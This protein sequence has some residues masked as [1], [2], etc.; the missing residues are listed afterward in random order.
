M[1]KLL[2]AASAIAMAVSVPAA[3][4]PDKANGGKGNGHAA[5]NMKPQKAERQAAKQHKQLKPQKQQAKFAKNERKAVQRQIKEENKRFERVREARWDD[6]R[7]VR[8]DRDDRFLDDRRVRSA[9]RDGNYDNCPP[10]LAKKNNGC[11]PPGQAKKIYARGDRF[12]SDIYRNYNLPLAYRGFYSDTPDYFYRY[13]DDGYIY[14]V[15]RDTSLVSGLIPL[16]GG[17]FGVG[18]VLPAGYDVYNVPLQY[19]DTYYDSD[20]AYYRYGDNAIYQVDPQSMM[21]E[22][23]VALLTGDTLGVGHMLPA[24]YD[25]YNVPWQYRDTYYDTP[26]SNYR[27]ADGYIYQVDPQTQIIQAVISALV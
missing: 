27:Y 18:Q 6:R 25:M 8:R 16:L 13:D 2:L 10:G 1:K 12:D 9:Y 20:D 3:A 26:Q 23:V 15:N 19:R 11:L 4:K 24:G 22:N 14:R 5:H 17:G 7:D 21:I